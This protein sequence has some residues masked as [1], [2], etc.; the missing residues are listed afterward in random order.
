MNYQ[1]DELIEDLSADVPAEP[2]QKTADKTALAVRND[3]A[4]VESAMSEFDKIS[5]GLDALA[6]RYPTDLVYDVT[7]GKGMVDAVAHRAAWREPRLTVERLR[8]QAKAPVLALG[9]SID[10]RAAWLTEQLLIGE[11]PIDQ[12]IKAEEARKEAIKQAKIAAEFGRVQAIQDAIAEIHMDAMVAAGKSA[13]VIA[14]ALES[15][16]SRILDPLVFQEL[17]SQAEAARVAAVAKMDLAHKA[18]LHTEAQAAQLAEERAE[19]ARLRAEAAERRV[20][21]EAEQRAARERIA[22]EQAAES[23]RLKAESDR[24]A[25]ERVVLEA[26]QASVNRA[27]AVMDEP[28]CAPVGPTVNVTGPTTI[29]DSRPPIKL[30]DVNERLGFTM[31]AAFVTGKLKVPPIPDPKGRA[32]LFAASDVPA[33]YSALIKHIEDIKGRALA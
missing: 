19:L 20:K 25:A 32:V 9:K 18:A 8:K 7:T 12:Q 14:E 6:E 5:A 11:T 22:A 2:V 21:E 26:Q 10:A 28:L 33:I 16:R 4:Q 31:T 15:M 17:L 30:G 29:T 13:A 24:L 1:A 27:P 23:L 3:I